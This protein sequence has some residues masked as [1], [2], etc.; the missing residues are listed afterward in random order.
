VVGD[1][2]IVDGGDG[3]AG[4]LGWGR[5]EGDEWGISMDANVTESRR[6]AFMP[7]DANL[8]FPRIYFGI[9]QSL[10]VKW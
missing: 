4:S 9:F 7:V 6:K 3:Q 1:G 5:P 10:C 2:Y 8:P